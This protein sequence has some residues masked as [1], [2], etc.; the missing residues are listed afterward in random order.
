[1]KKF[2][3]SAIC[4]SA[5]LMLLASCGK[6]DMI[7]LP[8]AED[9]ATVNNGDSVTDI[10]LS[11]VKDNGD[12]YYSITKGGT[13]RLFSTCSFGVRVTAGQNEDVRLILDGVDIANES[14]A[15]ICIDSCGNARVTVKD[16]TENHL[17][18]GYDYAAYRGAEPNACLFSKDGLTVDGGGTLYIYGRCNNGI[19]TK[20]DLQILSG[21]LVVSAPNNALKG[22]DSVAIIGGSIELSGCKDGIK[23]D[24]SD[25]GK[26]GCV[27]ILG[28]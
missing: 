4:I 21:S 25:D 27:S 12:G 23:N 17:T 19:G 2:I 13:Y 28:G 20:G 22:N 11:A 9:T 8:E 3:L 1:M 10:D 6:N 14:G 18:D 16:G 7:P 5:A 26:G 15:A 24:V